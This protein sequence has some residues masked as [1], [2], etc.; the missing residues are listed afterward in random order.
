MHAPR[1]GA[2]LLGTGRRDVLSLVAAGGRACPPSPWNAHCS[3]DPG[4]G[5][6]YSGLSMP[7][8]FASGRRSRGGRACLK[9]EP[10]LKRGQK[11]P[12]FDTRPGLRRSAPV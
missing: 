8:V 9:L 3:P 2:G 10:V 12:L 7:G 6:A 11:H 1:V 4:E 5:A